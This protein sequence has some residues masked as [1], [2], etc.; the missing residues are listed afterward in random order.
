MAS[1]T[2]YWRRQSRTM[3]MMKA[4]LRVSVLAV[5]ALT[6]S[7]SVLGF[8]AFGRPGFFPSLL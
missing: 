2:A 3:P 1:V 5:D 8:S 7:F 6:A 4:F